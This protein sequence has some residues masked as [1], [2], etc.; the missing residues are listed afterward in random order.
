VQVKHPNSTIAKFLWST[1]QGFF[2]T[3][4]ISL[5]VVQFSFDLEHFAVKT[6]SQ[7]WPCRHSSFAH[8]RG[9]LQ[10]ESDFG[11]DSSDQR[12]HDVYLGQTHLPGSIHS[13]PGQAH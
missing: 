3:L 9:L 1:Q 12:M 4:M 7:E 5:K 13:G 2:Q 10:K 6:D 8:S 11:E